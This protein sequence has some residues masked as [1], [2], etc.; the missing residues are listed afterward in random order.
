MAFASDE[1]KNVEKWINCII[2]WAALSRKD[3][4]IEFRSYGAL[5]YGG[6]VH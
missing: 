6:Y 1:H 4:I 5:F 3:D 2:L